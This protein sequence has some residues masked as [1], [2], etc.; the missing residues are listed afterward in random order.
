MAV[1][2]DDAEG[3]QSGVYIPRRDSNSL[4]NVLVGGRIYPG[5]HHLA[6]FDVHE[7][8]TGVHV[9][10]TARDGSAHVD[11]RA[12][13][14]ADLSDSVVFPDLEE[15]SRFFEH[16][17]VGFS[18]TSRPPRPQQ[19]NRFLWQAGSTGPPAVTVLLTCIAACLRIAGEAIAARLE[20]A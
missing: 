20:A 12:S 5:E 11:V 16:G 2:W 7:S 18:A 10:Y 1:E 8:D 13:L 3:T 9:A 6:G 19:P 4:I 15:A 14:A 17:S